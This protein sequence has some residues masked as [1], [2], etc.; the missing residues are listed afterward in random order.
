VKQTAR[1]GKQ[2]M[3]EP[4]EDAPQQVVAPAQEACD[5]SE[6]GL[7]L[8]KWVQAASQPDDAGAAADWPHKLLRRKPDNA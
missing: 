3:R 4:V 7:P 2:A 6:H 1:A 5:N 8:H